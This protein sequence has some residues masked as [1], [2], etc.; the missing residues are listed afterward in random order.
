MLKCIW[1]TANIQ[2]EQKQNKTKKPTHTHINAKASRNTG[3]EKMAA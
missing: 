1:E 3:V 2:Q